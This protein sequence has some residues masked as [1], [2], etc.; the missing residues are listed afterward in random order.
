MLFS[1]E[2]GGKREGRT[3][4]GRREGEG[5]E[6]RRGGKRGEEGERIGDTGMG[7]GGRERG[8]ELE[9][10]KLNTPKGKLRPRKAVAGTRQ[11]STPAGVSWCHPAAPPS[12][13][14][15]HLLH[16]KCVLSRI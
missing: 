3:R 15:E 9:G 1:E 2:K 14:R 16:A 4:E 11:L 10:E 8:K 6:G 13:P 7:R 12:L 5:E